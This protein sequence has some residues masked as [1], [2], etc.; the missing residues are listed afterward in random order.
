[1]DNT[2]SL[3]FLFRKSKSERKKERLKTKEKEESRRGKK[4][5]ERRRA[6][7]EEEKAL[8]SLFLCRLFSRSMGE[9]HALF[10]QPLSGEAKSS[11]SLS[12]L[13]SSSSSFFFC[14]CL[15]QGSRRDEDFPETFLA[16]REKKNE[17]TRSLFTSSPAERESLFSR[18]SVHF[19]ASRHSPV[20]PGSSQAPVLSH[21]QAPS[22]PGFSCLQILPQMAL[23]SKRERRES[24]L[25][26]KEE[27]TKGK[28]KRKRVER[29]R[30]REN[31]D[32]GRQ[33]TWSPVLH[34]ECAACFESSQL[35]SS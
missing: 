22:W 21:T 12:V 18:P 19:S 11:L 31:G 15:H 7:Y 32:E 23:H 30:K 2:R 28:E 3:F 6:R 27:K 35:P 4:S 17:D 25:M 16:F 29:A 14:S 1:M 10:L 8:P 9:G 34:G 24:P 5:G 20:L 33:R 26:C 13:L